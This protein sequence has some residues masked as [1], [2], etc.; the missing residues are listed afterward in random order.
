MPIEELSASALFAGE[1]PLDKAQA[2]IAQ[3]DRFRLLHSTDHGKKRSQLAALDIVLLS[4]KY[5]I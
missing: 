5:Y 2:P 3:P 4:K 1:F